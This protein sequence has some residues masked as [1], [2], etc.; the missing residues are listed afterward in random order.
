MKSANGQVI[1]TS[2][3]YT[4]LTACENGIDAIRRNCNVLRRFEVK[5]IDENQ[6]YFKLK[7]ANGQVIGISVMY[8]NAL[9]QDNWVPAVMNMAIL[10]SIE[11]FQIRSNN[12]GYYKSD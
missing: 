9:S 6:Y 4:I 11:F 3:K 12:P 2:Q 5:S 7:A 10:A 1:L 8:N